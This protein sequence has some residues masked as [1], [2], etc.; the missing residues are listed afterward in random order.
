MGMMRPGAAAHGGAIRHRANG[1]AVTEP[2]RVLDSDKP[3]T[4]KENNA[5]P[6]TDAQDME[7]GR[8]KARDIKGRFLGGGI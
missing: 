1:G 7:R 6:Y 3:E 4:D 2:D 8:E 5:P